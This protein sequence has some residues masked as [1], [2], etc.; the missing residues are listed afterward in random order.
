MPLRQQERRRDERQLAAKT[1]ECEGWEKQWRQAAMNALT[2]K[3]RD[4]LAEAR[5][6]IGKMELAIQHHEKRA[7]KA[8]EQRDK[9]AD[10]CRKLMSIIGPPGEETWA[11]D[12]DI[13]AAWKTGESALATLNQT[14]Q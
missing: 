10:A 6:V 1:E 5:D 13:E 2:D 9:L 7:D 8:T 3:T 4:E 11:D 14:T 12:F